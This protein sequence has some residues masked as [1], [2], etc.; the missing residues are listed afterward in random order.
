M[1]TSGGTSS[2]EF[3]KLLDS[4]FGVWTLAGNLTQ[5]IFQGGRILA[6]IDRNTALREQAVANYYD[7]ALR[8]FFEVETTLAAEQFIRREQA[9]L[10]IA[11][12]EATATEALA[13]DRYRSGTGDFLS[14]LD[15][16]RTADAARSRLLSVSNIFLQ[17]RVDLYLALGGAFESNSL[18]QPPSETAKKLSNTNG[19]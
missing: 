4:N 12:E 18:I 15:A 5:P 16:K 7:S 10:A 11:A 2:Q 3:E 17:N 1:T 13:W 19:G 9:K 14:A 8:A 6:N